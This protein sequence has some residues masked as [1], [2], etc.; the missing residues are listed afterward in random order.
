MKESVI[1]PVPS[2]LSRIPQA[3][4]DAHAAA[5]RLIGAGIECYVRRYHLGQVGWFVVASDMSYARLYF[6]EEIEL[7]PTMAKSNRR[8]IA[9]QGA[10]FTCGC[11]QCIRTFAASEIE[12]YTPDGSALCPHCDTDSVLP[13]ITDVAVLARGNERWFAAGVG[14]SEC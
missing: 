13:R 8:V 9:S 11:F 2:V 3:G 6:P 1:T 7:F 10:D 4:L 12:E 5:D 14:S